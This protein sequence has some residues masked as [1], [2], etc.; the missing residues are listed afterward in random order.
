GE[1]TGVLTTHYMEEIEA[2]ADT[3]AVMNKGKLFFFGT[4]EEMKTSTKKESVEEA[5]VVLVEKEGV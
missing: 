4:V 2:L 1:I 5:F 3:V